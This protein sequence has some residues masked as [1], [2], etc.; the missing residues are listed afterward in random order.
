MPFTKEWEESGFLAQFT[1]PTD[2]GEVQQANLQFFSDE[3]S[4]S[5]RYAIFDFSGVSSL[6][7][8]ASDLEGI[9][10]S[11]LGASFSIK[12]L[13]VALIAESG[14]VRKLCE[15]YISIKRENKSPWVYVIFD[16]LDSA[17]IWISQ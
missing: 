3:R 1:D 16:D 10:A 8:S 4:D 17:R 14:S 11:D 12:R 15:K 2:F 13:K 6:H 7:I 9:A 5:C